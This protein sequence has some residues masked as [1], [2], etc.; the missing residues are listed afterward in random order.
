MGPTPWDCSARWKKSLP[1]CERISQVKLTPLGQ[2]VGML[3]NGVERVN[4]T[5]RLPESY[6]L[7]GDFTP[8]KFKK[9]IWPVSLVAVV[10]LVASYFFFYWW[11]S[12][13]RPGFQTTKSLHFALSFERLGGLAALLGLLLVIF[14]IHELIHALCL[15]IYT[16]KRPVIRATL[17][18]G[19]G[20]YVRLPDLYLPR[21]VFLVVNLA[22]V[23]SITL[24]GFLLM[25]AVGQANLGLL[26]FCL[27]VHLAGA[28]GDLVS[29]VFI[30]LQPSS[31]YLTTDGLI[32]T[33]GS[34][35]TAAW[36]QKFR[37]ALLW[38]LDRLK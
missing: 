21:N 26:I 32:Y 37:S 25:F 14:A 8:D 15:W 35:N 13:I 30:F 24:I 11:A 27:A 38:M 18:G 2:S 6:Q 10:M 29:S 28:T 22:P 3:N 23:C 1:K 9:A 20:F 17:K 33:D 5:Q 4:S 12:L 7:Y 36:K 34:E 16:G 19:G 31:V